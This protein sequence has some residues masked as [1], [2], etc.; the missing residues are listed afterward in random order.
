M[1]AKTGVRK[2]R[3]I[4]AFLIIGCAVATALAGSALDV[5]AAG[6]TIGVGSTDGR[7]IFSPNI[8]TIAVGEAVTFTWVDGTHDARDSQSGAIYLPLSTSP[9]SKTTTFATAGTYYFYCSIHAKPTDATDANIATNARPVGK[10]IV[11]VP[12]T[13]AGGVLPAVGTAVP[14]VTAVAA[15]APFEATIS[16]STAPAAQAASA[17]LPV[18]GRGE[19]LP[20][21]LGA[22]AIFATAAAAVIAITVRAGR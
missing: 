8:V 2:H 4:A 18:E 10:I 1:P 19:F 15:K 22:I 14:T 17:G 11:Q 20:R 13:P 21:W 16:V 9:T 12:V 5:R 3:V 6:P 7:D